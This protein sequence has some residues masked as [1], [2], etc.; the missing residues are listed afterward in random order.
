MTPSGRTFRGRITGFV[1]EF[2]TKSGGDSGFGAPVEMNAA[3]PDNVV[4]SKMAPTASGLI[5]PNYH[6][7]VIDIDHVIHVEQSSTP[8]HSHLYIDKALTL[9]QYV[10][11]LQAMCDVGLV[12]QGYVDA[13][14]KRRHGTLRLP[15]VFK[16]EVSPHERVRRLLA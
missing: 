7:P 1:R 13:T 4:T 14:R 15:G 2:C 9:E 3:E 12:E 8:G 5:A 6:W 16:D 10:T 11:L